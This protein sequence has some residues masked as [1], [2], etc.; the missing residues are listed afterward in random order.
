MELGDGEHDPTRACTPPPPKNKNSWPTFR[1]V[2]GDGVL[3][4]AATALN[5]D[6][7]RARLRE[8]T[9]RHI[10]DNFFGMSATIPQASLF[11]MPSR[12]PRIPIKQHPP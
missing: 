4:D 3:S 5:N 2:L 8:T 10:A 11:S 1:H 12:V 9:T 7:R 6:M